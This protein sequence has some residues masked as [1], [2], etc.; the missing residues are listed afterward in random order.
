M[1][2]VQYYEWGNKVGGGGGGTAPADALFGPPEQ[3]SGVVTNVGA[4]VTFTRPTKWVDV[5]NQDAEHDLEVSFDGGGS[6]VTIP[7]GGSLKEELI[8]TSILLLGNAAGTDYEVV[9]ALQD[10]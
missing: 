2:P 9:A 4:T 6:Y 1:S 3:F 10:A 8:T 7:S 5:L